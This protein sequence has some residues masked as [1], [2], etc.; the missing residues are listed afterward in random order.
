MADFWRSCGYHLLERGAD[1]QLIVTDDYLRA[2]YTRPELAPGMASCPGE[3]K[4]HAAL[5]EN[6]RR[7]IDEQQ[8]AAL[9]DEDARENHRVMLRF[10]DQLLAAPSLEAFYAGLFKR[11]V[12]VPP[13][14]IDQTVQVILRGILDAT[15]N[16]LIARAAELFFRAQRVS[17]DD[18]AIRLADHETVETH[19]ASAG[20]ISL[21][22]R[23]PDAPPRAIELDVLDAAT[24]AEYWRRDER[25][26]TVLQ[27]NSSHPGCAALCRVIEAWI[28][29]FHRTPVTVSPVRE[30]PDPDWVWHVGLDAEATAMLNEI[31]NGG[32][33]E[34]ERMHRIIGLF[35]VDFAQP[36]AMRAE[37][38]GKPV[39]LGLA[40][41][42]DYRLRMKP[43]NL[44]TNLPL[45][46]PA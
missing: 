43:Q 4:L 27:L 33:V 13:L 24:E 2:Y 6:P 20:L 1:G 29:H 17:I 25:F 23:A 32:E 40:A 26:D 46:R 10:R 36:A 11:D 28:A 16:G 44:L 5:M 30:I 8:I 14:F 38:A 42:A 45:S 21:G 22:R 39:Y 34:P 37:I 9:R 18:G 7:D 31:Y 12:A 15:E 3:L 19:A 41:T 35:R